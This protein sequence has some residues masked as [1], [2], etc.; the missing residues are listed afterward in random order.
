[1]WETV[2]PTPIRPSAEAVANDLAGWPD[3]LTR[4][5]AY[6]GLTLFRSGRHVF[7][8]IGVA[9]LAQATLV[10]AARTRR[11]DGLYALSRWLIYA[12]ITAVG[13]RQRAAVGS[14]QP[15]GLAPRPDAGWFGIVYTVD[16]RRALVRCGAGHLWPE[17]RVSFAG[18]RCRA[19][20]LRPPTRHAQR[21]RSPQAAARHPAPSG[22]RGPRRASGAKRAGCLKKV[23]SD[24][25][26][27][28]ARGEPN[29]SPT[30]LLDG[31]RRDR[32]HR[33]VHHDAATY[34]SPIGGWDPSSHRPADAGFPR[35]RG[36]VLGV[37]GRK[38]IPSS[39][40][41]PRARRE[42]DRPVDRHRRRAA[43]KRGT[44]ERRRSRRDRLEAVDF[45]NKSHV[46]LD[47]HRTARS[48]P[49]RRCA[50]AQ[51]PGGPRVARPRPRRKRSRTMAAGRSCAPA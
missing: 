37:V 31:H 3:R 35:P 2:P 18:A 43:R 14:G 11:A 30:I 9:H 46:A 16:G 29:G 13:A 26:G 15:A 38:P 4:V 1:M 41:G 42:V 20:A 33:A 25:S 39:R 6:A 12:P 47:R 51:R 28:S 49:W 44:L 27:N 24:V 48:S 17:L 40:P 5:R 7:H 36:D 45:P 8:T 23:T 21:H 32:R 34:F 19:S 50:P 10:G 22:L